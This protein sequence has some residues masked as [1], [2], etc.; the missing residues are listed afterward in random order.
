[1]V[2]ACNEPCRHAGVMVA[3]SG[4]YYASVL[5]SFQCTHVA[6]A[7]C[8]CVFIH[9]DPTVGSDADEQPSSK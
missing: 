6:C 2:A 1:M 9:Y 3:L 8:V 5:A 4:V 7:L